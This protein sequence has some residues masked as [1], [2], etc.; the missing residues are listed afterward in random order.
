MGWVIGFEGG[1]GQLSVHF[2]LIT[3]QGLLIN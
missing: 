2:Y 1:D 3:K